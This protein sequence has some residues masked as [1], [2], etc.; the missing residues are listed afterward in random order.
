MFISILLRTDTESAARSGKAA[1]SF[2][3]LF[4]IFILLSMSVKAFVTNLRSP[5]LPHWL[6]FVGMVCPPALGI[7]LNVGKWM[8]LF[9]LAELVPKSA[10]IGIVIGLWV[11]YAIVSLVYVAKRNKASG[12]K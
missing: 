5:V 12:P 7:I 11:T 6:V 8:G 9:N 1:G 3:G 2:M 4:I 10:G